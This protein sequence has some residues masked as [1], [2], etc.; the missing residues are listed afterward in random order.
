MNRYT[1]EEIKEARKPFERLSDRELE[2][3]FEHIHNGTANIQHHAIL[4]IIDERDRRKEEV[5]DD[6]H[7][8]SLRV[9]ESAKRFAI[10]AVVVSLLGVLSTVLIGLYL[11]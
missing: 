9:A 7:K 8:T 10:W 11:K 3:Q 6:R 1:I 2:R 5:V 4:E